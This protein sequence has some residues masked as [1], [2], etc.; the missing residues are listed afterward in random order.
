MILY[1]KL[2]FNKPYYLILLDN[3][4]TNHTKMSENNVSKQNTKQSPNPELNSSKSPKKKFN[5]IHQC[6]KLKRKIK[7]FEESLDHF[8][9]TIGSKL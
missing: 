7:M 6:T 8:N 3:T 4:I 1:K 9:Q 5:I 2:I